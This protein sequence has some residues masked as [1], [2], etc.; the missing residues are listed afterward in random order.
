MSE[1]LVGDAPLYLPEAE[2][3][4]FCSELIRIDTT[5]HGGGESAGERS[6]AEYV[7]GKLAE[8]G[9]ESTIYESAPGRANLVAHWEGVDQSAPPLLVHG[10]LDVVPA[11]RADWRLDPLSGEVVEDCVWGRGAVD[12]KG[13]NAMVLSV[14]RARQRAG[15]KPRRPVRLIFTADEEGGCHLGSQWLVDQHPDTIADC[16]EA[17]GEVGGFSVTVN[18]GQRLYLIQ[19]AEKGNAWMRL[20]SRGTAGHGSMANRNNAVAHIAEAVARVA[21]YDWPT[22]ITPAVRQLLDELSAM[23]GTTLDPKNLEEELAGIGRFSWMLGATV[24][25]TANPTMLKAGYKVNVIPGE[26]EAHVDGRYL[27]GLDAEFFATIDELLGDRVTREMLVDDA[28]MA[29]DFSGDLVDAMK[30]ALRAEDSQSRVAPMIWSG[31][32]DAKAWNRLGVRCYGFM[33]LRLPAGLDFLGMFHGVDERVPTSSLEFG[34]RVL[35]HFLDLA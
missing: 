22:R 11:D 10:H 27:P 18:S 12:M 35:D 14:V 34:A 5:N 2:A 17:I 24:S 25:N 31:G 20:S 13:F 32:T 1:L 16:T 29:V 4:A 3:V 26:A 6:A 21:S 15:V 8:V 19:T 30:S 33:P 28:G 7:A 23:T 9:I